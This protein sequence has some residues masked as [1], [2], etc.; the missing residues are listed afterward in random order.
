MLPMLHLLFEAENR[1]YF[2][3]FQSV[4]MLK[5]PLSSKYWFCPCWPLR[6][7]W[8]ETVWEPI[9]TSCPIS[10]QLLEGCK[11]VYA[12]AVFR[13]WLTYPTVLQ[14]WKIHS[15]CQIISWRFDAIC[16]KPRVKTIC[17]VFPKLCRKATQSHG[18]LLR[19]ACTHAHTHTQ[20]V[21]DEKFICNPKVLCSNEGGEE[22]RN[23]GS[24][25]LAQILP[26]FFNWHWYGNLSAQNGHSISKPLAIADS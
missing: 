21:I 11:E 13:W 1:S 14:Q 22:G 16:E 25:V 12:M 5:P 18:V 26:L 10:C 8:A 23:M 9:E 19:R 24:I 7:D 15:L 20:R 6:N 4:P 2:S 3:L 17:F